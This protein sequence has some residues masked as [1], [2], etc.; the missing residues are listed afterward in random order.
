MNSKIFKEIG[1]FMVIIVFISCSNNRNDIEPNP[2]SNGAFI[3]TLDFVNS[4]II[5]GDSESAF[6]VNLEVEDGNN[7]R[8][9]E[10]IEV[11]VQYKNNNMGGSNTIFNE[12]LIKT[13]PKEEFSVGN[14]G[15]PEILLNITYSE[16]ISAT[17]IENTQCADQ[18]LIRLRLNLSNGFSFSTESNNAPAIIGFDTDISSPFCYTINVV[19]PIPED[20]FIGLYNYV[21]IINGPLGPTFG[22][23]ETIELKRGNS[24][25]DRYFEGQYVAARFDE[26]RKYRFIFTCNEVVFRKNQISSFFT[27]CQEGELSG[28][29]TFGGPPIL[30]GP[31]EM[32]GI[33]AVN[34]DSFFELSILEGYL[35][36]DGECGFGAVPVK[37]RFTKVD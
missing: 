23:P 14:N 22:P 18:F 16:L 25:N 37:V 6:G 11:F 31:N 7:G 21:S 33:A 35:G 19:N 30:L 17:G 1:N 3:R 15:L 13:L 12:V 10:T 27:W 24:V 20:H 8:L 28:G 29:I 26:T 32:P 36:W 4:D 2:A 34:D 5:L 9:L